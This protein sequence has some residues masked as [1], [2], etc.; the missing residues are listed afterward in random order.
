MESFRRVYTVIA[1]QAITLFFLTLYYWHTRTEYSLN[2]L[3]FSVTLLLGIAGG[4]FRGRAALLASLAAV[5]GCGAYTGYRLYFSGL[6]YEPVWND[7]IWLIAFP[8]AALVGGLRASGGKR[9]RTVSEASVSAWV[10]E[11]NT[12]EYN[13]ILERRF[14]IVS[15]A[16]L[17]KRLD[18]EISVKSHLALSLLLIEVVA[19]YDPDVQDDPEP[20]QRLLQKIGDCIFDGSHDSFYK[21]YLGK[22]RFAVLLA[23]PKQLGADEFRIALEEQVQS[24]LFSRARRS[25]A[26]KINLLFGAAE[27][28]TEGADAAELLRSAKRQ[29]GRIGPGS[30]G[31]TT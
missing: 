26:A 27:H 21:A 23:G 14:E 18:D 28:P 10:S 17:L 19:L 4:V 2:D 25:A 9:R 8:Y 7:L 31:G 15:Q 13:D 20:T 30:K 6:F 5:A 11:D 12:L 1:V 29:F 22:G 16:D 3:W 24:F